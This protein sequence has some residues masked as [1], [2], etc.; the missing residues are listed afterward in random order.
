MRRRAEYEAFEFAL[1]PEG[2]L[3]F[4]EYLK[5]RIAM[6]FRGDYAQFRHTLRHELVHYFQLSKLDE[7]RALHPGRPEFSPQQIHWWTEGLAEYWSSEQTVEDR[8]YIRDLVV[9]GELP[10]IARFTRSRSFMAYPL[11]AELHA[12]LADR[13]G[14]DHIVELYE[15]YWKY[16]SFGAALAGVLGVSLETVDHAFAQALQRRFFPGYAARPPGATAADRLVGERGNS[17]MPTLYTPPG[18]TAPELFFLSSRTGYTNIY[19]MDLDAEEKEPETVVEGQRRPEFASFHAYESRIDVSRGGVIAF[20]SEYLERDALF[21]WDLEKG[22]VVGRYQ[23]P[24]LVGLRSP[25]WHPSGRRIVFE[26]L[27]VQ[28]YSDLY[29]LDFRSQRRIALTSDRFRDTDPDW[30]P[31]GETIVFASDRTAFGEDGN[32]NLFLLDVDARRGR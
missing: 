5:R 23:W 20:V 18:D 3:G 2:V 28:G 30:S 4:T 12:F 7:T 22:E 9:N 13:Y 27:S 17:Y 6:P 10:S 8:M 26:G 11:G 16:D 21:L 15:D 29:V 14:E 1:I 31:D 19:R 24:D 32:T 25:A